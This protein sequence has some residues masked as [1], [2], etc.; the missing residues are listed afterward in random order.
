MSSRRTIP[1]R[2]HGRNVRVF[3]SPEVPDL[4]KRLLE[5]QQLYPEMKACVIVRGQRPREVPI[6]LL[7]FEL[8]SLTGPLKMAA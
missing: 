5:Y 7:D 6:G 3:S 4:L 8:S 2:L 1:A